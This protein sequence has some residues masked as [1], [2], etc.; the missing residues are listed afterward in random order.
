MRQ[1]IIAAASRILTN[2]LRLALTVAAGLLCTHATAASPPRDKGFIMTVVSY[3]SDPPGNIREAP[4]GGRILTPAVLY[5]PTAGDNPFGPAIVMLDEGPGSHPLERNQASRFVAET[6]AKAG[7][8]V[9]SVYDGQERGFATQPFSETAYAVQGALDYLEVMGHEHFVLV[10]QSYGAIV[11]AYYLATQKDTLLD[12]GGE[13]RVKAVVLLDPLTE[14]RRYPRTQQLGDG[15]EA[16]VAKAEAS[17]ASGRGTYPKTLEPGHGAGA[18]TDPWILTGPYVAPAEGFLD[19]WGPKAAARNADA[20]EKLAVPTLIIASDRDDG[21]SIDK[22]RALHTASTI[23][24]RILPGADPHFRGSEAAVA[25]DIAK[26]LAAHDLG[27]RP[28]VRL[29][30]IDVTADDGHVLQGVLYTPEGVDVKARPAVML[31]S[32]RTGDTV[33]SSTH[34]MGWRIAQQGYAVFAPGMRISGTA[35]VESHTLADTASD[36]GHWIDRAAALGYR[37]VVMAGHSNGGIWLSNYLSLTHDKRVVGTIYYA[38]TR[39]EPTYTRR[40]DGDVVFD[41]K[42]RDAQAAVAAGRGAITPIGLLSA[43]SFLDF[44]GPDSRA[45]HTERVKEFDL[46][47]LAIVGGKD[48][49]M[50]PEF[51]AEFKQ[52][53]RGPLEVLRYPDAS[54]GLRESKDRVGIDTAAWLAKT[55]APHGGVRP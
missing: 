50:E 28:R 27:I 30:T 10:G 2:S 7:Y 52:D 39:D 1:S 21:I 43:N 5:T 41:Q 45:V 34:W 35:G 48:G 32:G 8:T 53:Y 18:N 22:L 33:Q 4:G 42:V 3:A 40:L 12:N 44:T 23:E 25:R 37:R 54:H 38:P 20:L 31:V 55:F 17:V 9:L 29:D 16:L 47:G 11:A 36:L 6:L 14:L 51:V 19:Y 26:W 46:P 13:K 15:Y 24:L 49:L